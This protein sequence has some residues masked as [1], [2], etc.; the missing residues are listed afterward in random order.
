MKAR[1]SILVVTSLVLALVLTTACDATIPF[2]P[3]ETPGAG[4]PTNTPRIMVSTDATKT[5]IAAMQTAAPT[6]E[7]GKTPVPTFTPIVPTTPGATPVAPAAGPT[8]TSMPTAGPGPVSPAQP[9]SPP[10]TGETVYVVQWGDTLSA[11]AWRHGTTVAAIVQR[12][13]IADPSRIYVGQRLI[14]PVGGAQPGP[15]GTQIHIVQRGESLWLIAN[16]Y[17][18]TVSAIVQANNIANPQL[19]YA[20]QRL[21]IPVGGGQSGGGRTYVVQAGDTLSAIALRYGTT[22]MAIAMANNLANPS[23]IYP[24]Q[25][26]I[27]P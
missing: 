19:I 11:I 1:V 23:L 5:A 2:A 8:P 14:I 20:G 18:T 12:N 16:K 17:G 26:L 3:L 9:V 24:G 22:A 25:I 13:G 6:T 10:T 15:G 27:I 4:V 7:P 21:V